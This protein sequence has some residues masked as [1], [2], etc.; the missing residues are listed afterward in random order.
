MQP[1]V[2]SLHGGPPPKF[3]VSTAQKGDFPRGTPL[4]DLRESVATV[5]R[6]Q[7]YSLGITARRTVSRA[8]PG[9]LNPQF[10]NGEYN[11]PT[12]LPRIGAGSLINWTGFAKGTRG[13]IPCVPPRQKPLRGLAES[14]KNHQL[15]IGRV[16]PKES[17]GI[18]SGGLEIPTH[19]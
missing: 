7:P 6:L 13:A 18:T 9:G 1:I 19:F 15:V 11:P 4:E 8:T 14:T 2:G 17:E 16:L 10:K 5:A 3:P 12:P